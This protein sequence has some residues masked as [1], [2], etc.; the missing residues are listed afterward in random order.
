MLHS[1]CT[2]QG[3]SHTRFY[4]VKVFKEAIPSF[5]VIHG[6]LLLLVGYL[7]NILKFLL[8]VISNWLVLD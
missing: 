4:L 1:F 7:R 8:K 5:V 6:H 3:F 2:F